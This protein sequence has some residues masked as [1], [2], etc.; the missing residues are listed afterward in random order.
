MAVDW[1]DILVRCR[2]EIQ[3]RITPLLREGEHDQPDLG[4]GAGGDQIREVD[5]VAEDAIVETLEGEGISCTLVSEEAGVKKFGSTPDDCFVTVDPVDGTTNLMRGIPFYGTSIAVSR[6]PVI[7]D[8]HTALV[9]DLVHDITYTARK[10]EGAYRDEQRIAPSQTGSLEN[11]VIGVDLNT[12]QVQEIAAQ[13]TELIRKTK[14]IRHLGA[15]ALE[16]CH[17]AD[18][19]TDAFVDMRGKLRTTDMAAAWLILK[20]AGG[21]ITGM[22]GRSLEVNLSPQQKVAFIAAANQKIYALMLKA[23]TGKG[24]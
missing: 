7:D 14:H 24:T 5:L 22:Q 4:V 11:A 16:I 18:G 17:V 2:D 15:N 13:L 1:L 21:I 8:V 6:N 12:Y 3:D 19:T 20:E 10:G 9:A 23:M